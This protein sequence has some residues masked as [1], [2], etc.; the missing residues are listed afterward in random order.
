VFDRRSA[1]ELGILVGLSVGLGLLHLAVRSDLA[2]IGEPPET[3]CG[4][5]DEAAQSVER[6]SAQ[7]AMTLVGDPTVT[8]VDAR[9]VDSYL[10]GHIPGAMSLPADEAAGVLEVQSVPIPP[11]NLVVTYCDGGTCEQSEYL[12]ILLEDRAGCEQVK[13][14]ADGWVAWTSAEAP[15]ETGVP[16]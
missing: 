2:W 8:F 14:M 11:E 15:V 3:A 6:I 13:V 12:G 7:E 4:S 5:A 1:K 9:S 10:A 16:Q